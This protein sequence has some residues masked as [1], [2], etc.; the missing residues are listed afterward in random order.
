MSFVLPK[1]L[2]VAWILAIAAWG[3]LPAR[4]EDA[5]LADPGSIIL[6]VVLAGLAA[7]SYF[8]AEKPDP[9]QPELQDPTLSTRGSRIPV[10]VGDNVIK[11]VIG[12]VGDRTTGSPIRENAWHILCTGPVDEIRA[13]RINGEIV[14]DAVY[15]SVSASGT[16]F[17]ADDDSEA[18]GASF[19]VYWGEHDQPVNTFLAEKWRVA[20]TEGNAISS[21]WPNVCYLVWEDFPTSAGRWPEI[22]YE[23]IVKPNALDTANV[24]G[25][26]APLTGSEDYWE[27][28]LDFADPTTLYEIAWINYNSNEVW[29]SSTAGTTQQDAQ[30]L[31]G[32]LR[33]MDY[34]YFL[35]TQTALVGATQGIYRIQETPEASYEQLPRAPFNNWDDGLPSQSIKTSHWV[36][37]V[38]LADWA[39]EANNY[40]QTN[41]LGFPHFPYYWSYLYPG[42]AYT[43]F[44][45][46]QFRP[47]R[48]V[49]PEG[50]NG[51]HVL[52]QLLFQPFP[53][54]AGMDIS[55][56]DLT[57][58]QD[59]GVLLET[60][61]ISSH[62][63]LTQG[64][65]L[66]S[67]VTDLMLDLGVFLFRDTITGQLKVS[68]QR[69][70]AGSIPYFPR[71]FVLEPLPEIEQV[72][73]D[74]E[75]PTSVVYTFDDRK[76]KFEKGTV[77]IHNDG[78]IFYDDFDNSKKSEL[79]TV[80]DFVTA[81]R[82]AARRSQ[83]E[84]SQVVT[85]KMALN[86]GARELAPGDV[87][88][89]EG[90]D[91]RM[92]CTS[93][94]PDTESGAVQVEAVRDVYGL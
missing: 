49:K 88:E 43:K 37:K 54:G 12:W 56:W 19:T 29:L 11:P 31:A 35:T 44:N 63:S 7:A 32:E 78:R 4:A 73:F 8:M 5:A 90:I 39:A 83:E 64:D 84:L 79:P 13:I 10:V 57:S 20:D 36:V 81:E 92:R 14:A 67:A 15:R 85:V 2:Y 76:N 41:V 21:R 87:F 58:F 3:F 93:V 6:S 55:D 82:I 23:V 53:W 33:T 9:E 69:S 1:W 62:V 50:A 18:D 24:T 65:P 91:F 26:V 70:V 47:M 16:K 52:H 71:D 25:A 61:A 68:A 34:L 17:Q 74:A 27:S 80:R 30:N 38:R 75:T 51:S 72:F 89:V 22:E 46:G 94:Q 42:T 77:N 40:N 86:R 66:V 45:S 60:E 59:L 48:Y 28:V